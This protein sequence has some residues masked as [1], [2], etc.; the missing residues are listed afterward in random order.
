MNRLL[1]KNCFYFILINLF[2]LGFTSKVK[3]QNIAVSFLES[4]TYNDTFDIDI[5]MDSVSQAGSFTGSIQLDTTQFSLIDIVDRTGLAGSIFGYNQLDSSYI[6]GWF[7][8]APITQADTIFTITLV[9]KNEFC[10]RPINWT[11]ALQVSDNLGVILPSNFTNGTLYFLKEEQPSLVYPSPN[12]SNIPINTLFQWDGNNLDCINSYR[13]QL[14][15][16]TNFTQILVDTVLIDT[17]LAVGGMQ[18]L[19]THHYRVTKIDELDNEYFS[20]YQ[21]FTTQLLDTISI[22]IEEVFTFLDSIIIPITIENT[23]Y[24][25]GFDLAIDFDTTAYAGSNFQN[26]LNLPSG[27]IFINDTTYGRIELS[28]QATN[29]P[30]IFPSDTIFEIVF[31]K[32]ANCNGFINWDTIGQSSNFYFNNEIILPANF[33][34]GDAVFLDTLSVDLIFPLDSSEQVFIRPEM[35]WTSIDCSN[36]YQ[37]QMAFDANFTN[38][39]VDTLIADTIFTPINLLGDTTYYWRVG[40]NNAV[41]SLYLSDVWEFRTEIVFPV[42]IRTDDVITQVDTFVFPIQIDS[43]ENTIAF[44]LNLNYDTASIQFLSY[45]DTTTFIANLIVQD[46]NGVIQISWESSDSTLLSTANIVSDTLLQLRFARKS[47][48]STPLTWNT[49]TS[50]FYH[51]NEVIN[52]DAF[53]DNSIVYFINDSTPNL[54]IPTNNDTT[55]LYTDIVWQPVPCA[56]QYHLAVALD[57]QFTQVIL[58][59]I[60][61]DTAVWLTNLQPN[62]TYFWRVAKEDLLG[63]LYWSDTLKFTT[64]SIYTTSIEIE[65]FLTYADTM[66]VHMLIDSS[67]YVT[68]FDLFLDYNNTE[69]QFLGFNNTLFNTLQ[70]TDNS[71]VLGVFWQDTIPQFII[72]D[73]LVTLRF[74]NISACLTPFDWNISA[75]NFTYRA[76]QNLS[77]T[78]FQSSTVEFLNR[79]NPTLIAPFDEETDVEPTVN[80]DWQ[81]VNCTVDYQFQIAEDSNFV[82]LILDSLNLTDT[83]LNK[84]ILNH[85]TTYYW[86]VGRWD[87]QNDL[88][89]SDTLTFTTINLPTIFVRTGDTLTYSDTLSVPVILENLIKI[90]AFELQLNYDNVAMQFL[91]FT[92]TLFDMNVNENSGNINIEWTTENLNNLLNITSDTILWMR[93]IPNKDCYSDLIWN[94][95]II[96]FTYED[97]TAVIDIAVQNGL[98]FWINNNPP[99]LSFP[100][101]DST[102]LPTTFQLR[103]EAEICAEAYRLQ[104]SKVADFSTILLDFPNISINSFGILGLENNEKYYWRVGQTDSKGILHWSEIWNFKTD[105]TDFQT[106]RVYP[107][108]TADKLTIWFDEMIENPAIISI[109]NIAGQLIR[110]YNIEENSKAIELNLGYLSDGIYILKYQSEGFIFTEKII[111]R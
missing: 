95:N 89:W 29:A 50:D 41:D 32:K 10:N 78:Q 91:D 83:F 48:C 11:G 23:E 2:I 70:I 97:T 72:Q 86:R 47:G 8:L 12:S 106:Y 64:G 101:N 67:F 59:S 80:F 81:S 3:S 7:N 21:S 13:F 28:W 107:N 6:I 36:N 94:A 104:F 108:P 53:Y 68:E 17:V 79:D 74:A 4:Y 65:S 77:P 98:L 109:F 110:S 42:F 102:F 14:A 56:V 93:F 31:Y 27:N 54:V 26:I 33:Q 57:N 49:A 55:L 39:Q 84:I 100:P 19:F 82:T 73:T 9:K 96:N 43:L 20:P 76:N 51:I 24:L 35:T 52:I 5:Y 99:K 34:N 60:Q 30:I 16:D 62:T 37:V 71:G 18:S 103:W 90:Q 45:F 1:T 25:G 63:D 40:R 58:D 66:E 88:Y 38:I 85:T 44:E 61:T 15:T 69:I 22:E 105:R 46:T 87:S 75:S 111:V 92:D